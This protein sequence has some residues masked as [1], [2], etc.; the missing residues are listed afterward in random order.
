MLTWPLPLDLDAMNTAAQD[1][2]GLRDFASFC[3]KREGAT[4]VRTLLALE[5]TRDADGLAVGRVVADAFCHNMVRSLVGCLL[6]VG[7][8]RREPGWAAEVMT[9]ARRDPSITVVKPHGL[10]LEEVGYPQRTELLAQA[11]RARARRSLDRATPP[12]ATKE[13]S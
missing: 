6:M 3:K 13:T 1:L 8:G 12:A 10:T 5:W 4:T 2:L 9:A 11:E 7:E